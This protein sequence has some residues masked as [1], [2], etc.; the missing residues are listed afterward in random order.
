[1]KELEC[2]LYKLV[3]EAQSG[4]QFALRTIIKKFYPIVLKTRKRINIQEQ[5]DLEQEILEKMI[6]AILTFDLNTPVDLTHFRK[7]IKSFFNEEI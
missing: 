4:H 2:Q 3:K 5:D 6:R 7:S 1:M